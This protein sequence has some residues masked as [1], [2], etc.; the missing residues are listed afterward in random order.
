MLLQT[1]ANNTITRQL[2]NLTIIS[3]YNENDNYQLTKKYI[4]IL[5]T[6]ISPEDKIEIIFGS[7]IYGWFDQFCMVGYGFLLLAFL[8]LAISAVS[9]QILML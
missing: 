9:H 3:K 6:H 7:Y 2:H 4:Y 8:Y 5:I 1:T